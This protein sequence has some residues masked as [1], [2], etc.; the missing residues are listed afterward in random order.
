MSDKMIGV[1][2]SEKELKDLKR[3]QSDYASRGLEL[4]ISELTRMSL[5]RTFKEE[6]YREEQLQKS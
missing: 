1:R 3:L 2:L 6:L 4:T 5:R